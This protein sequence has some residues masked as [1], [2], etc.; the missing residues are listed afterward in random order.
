MHVDGKLELAVWY[1]NFQDVNP[2]GSAKYIFERMGNLVAENGV[3]TLSVPVGSFFTVS[4]ILSGPT[5]GSSSTP[6]PKSQ[7]QMPLP[8]SDDFESQNESQEGKWWSDQIGAFEVHKTAEAN[9]KVMRQMV[10]ELPIGWSDHGSNGPFTLLG[11][12]EWQDITISADLMIPS[13]ILGAQ[14]CIATR[15]DQMWQNGIVLCVTNN[16]TFSLSIGGPKLGGVPSGYVIKSGKIS[17]LPSGFSRLALTTVGTTASASVN[18][19]SLFDAVVIRGVDTGFAGL[20]ASHWMPI[21]FDN[22]KITAAGSQWS[23]TAFPKCETPVVGTELRAVD[24]T[25]NGLSFDG[26]GFDLLADWGIRHRATGLCASAIDSTSGSHIDLQKCDP[27]NPRQA[28]RNSYTNVR[29]WPVPFT[30]ETKGK[31][32]KLGGNLDGTIGVSLGNASWN[33][34]LYFPNSK[35]LRNQYTATSPK[36]AADKLGYPKCLTACGTSHVDDGLVLYT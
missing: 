7:P 15:A 24:C 10:P 29:N 16:G 31:P 26:Q 5:K 19:V 20:G 30:L 32:L 36:G 17:P 11:M 14:G 6:V 22:V 8:Y 34:W 1:S 3:F 13:A 12:R 27:S 18:G 2:D 9:T 23:P 4:T 35:Q 21:E 33:T 25:R 28:F